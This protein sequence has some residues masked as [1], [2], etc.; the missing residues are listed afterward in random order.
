MLSVSHAVLSDFPTNLTQLYIGLMVLY[1]TCWCCMI[2]VSAFVSVVKLVF[3]SLF[4]PPYRHLLCTKQP[5]LRL[6]FCHYGSTIHRDTSH[7]G[8]S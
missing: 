6:C 5:V 7:G 8:L 1:D 3:V 2:C 4:V